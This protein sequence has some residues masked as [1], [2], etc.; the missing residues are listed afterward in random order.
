MRFRFSLLSGAAL[1]A[2]GACTPLGIT[3]VDD[4]SE[5]EIAL[6]RNFCEGSGL[7]ACRFVNSP[8]RLGTEAVRV[9]GRANKFFRTANRLEFTDGGQSLWIASRD[10]LTDGASIPRIFVPIVGLPT[11]PSFVNAAAVHDAHCGIGNENGPEF[12]SRTWEDTHRMFYDALRVGGTPELKAKIMFA[13]V[14]LGGPRW[15]AGGRELD[16][17]PQQSM[18][19]TLRQVIGFIRS[20][21][22]TVPQIEAYIEEREKELLRQPLK[23]DSSPTDP[24]KVEDEPTI[25]EPEEPFEPEEPVIN[26]EPPVTPVPPILPEPPDEPDTPTIDPEFP[27]GFNPDGDP[28]F[29]SPGDGEDGFIDPLPCLPSITECG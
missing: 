23:E 16:G 15:N 9:P 25:I 10:T 19:A 8:V 28:D 6:A 24:V 26:P 18:R 11:S 4:L 27:D 1:L 14:Y 7:A 2:L 21:N 22:P 3:S 20:A 29:G 5:A 12:H 17:V 13:A